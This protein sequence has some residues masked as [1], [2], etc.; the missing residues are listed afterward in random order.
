M[1]N[2][3]SSLVSGLVGLALVAS[4]S[5]SA[6]TP[7]APVVA[8]KASSY[9]LIGVSNTGSVRVLNTADW[10]ITGPMLTGQLGSFGGGLFDVVVTPDGKTA[11]ISNFGDS[12]VTILDMTNPLVPTI[13][14]KVQLDFFAEDMD[15]TPDGRYALVTDGGFSSKIF[16][17]DI[18]ARHG[19]SY[20]Y[21]FQVGGNS[22]PHQPQMQAVSIMADGRTV[23]CP[24]YWNGTVEVFLL[25]A[26]GTPTFSQSLEIPIQTNPDPYDP[27]ADPYMPRPINIALS[28]DG[29]H[30]A[31]F[32]VGGSADPGMDEFGAPTVFLC[33]RIA[34][35]MIELVADNGWE[36]ANNQPQS[37]VFSPDGKKLYVSAHGVTLPAPLLRAGIA[38][39]AGPP[40]PPPTFSYVR[41]FS[42]SGDTLSLA[43]DIPIT[44]RGTSQLFGVDTI[45]LDQSGQFVVV[46]NPTLSGA[47]TQIDVISTISNGVIRTIV[48]PDQSYIDGNG[49]PQTDPSIPVG[50]AFNRYPRYMRPGQ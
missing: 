33:K 5:L 31:V 41:V 10:S 47:V 13:K 20:S 36:G 30:A 34:P 29:V 49:D 2:R 38:L 23:L 8:S 14:G 15:I 48:L 32:A 35:G 24:N 26:E 18:K 46:T 28:P 42:V 43:Q 50:I 11:L 19:R 12:L 39:P 1:Q 44:P 16:V 40:P 22:N 21:D 25:D 3:K 37:G 6:L 27:P 7:A 4:A 17:I 9:G 45:A